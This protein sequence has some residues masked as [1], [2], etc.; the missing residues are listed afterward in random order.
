MLV[1]AS[2][3]SYRTYGSPAAAGA[4]AGNRQQLSDDEQ[5]LVARLQARD[6]EVR[7]HE[8]AHLA[9][10]GGLAVSGASYSYQR[11]PDGK[12]YAI[13]GEV[14]IDVSPGSTPEETL[15]KAERIRA[16]A[17]APAN[18]SGQ[19]RAVAAQA[20]SMAQ[21][22]QADKATRGNENAANGEVDRSA[23]VNRAY[24]ANFGT[25]SGNRIQAWA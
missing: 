16:A 15:A 11:G 10:A 19:D 12:N 4:Q 14:G 24:S 22:A 20:A 9:A 23:A 13:G 2:S 7:Q 17:L 18:P 8:Q 3:A 6:R 21:E 25:A 1:A 5:Q